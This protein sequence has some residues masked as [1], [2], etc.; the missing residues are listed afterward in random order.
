[1]K[2]CRDCGIPMIGVMSFSKDEYEKF[3]QCPKRREEAKHIQIRDNEL[4][5]REILN[6]EIYKTKRK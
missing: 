6:K 1:M 4:D 5:F 3:C 2:V